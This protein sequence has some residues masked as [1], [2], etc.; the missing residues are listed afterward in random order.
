MIDPRKFLFHS[1]YKID[2][3]LGTYTGSLYNP[4]P[5]ANPFTCNT[6]SVD[7]STNIND[8]TF[9]QGIY[10]INGG[11]TWNDLNCHIPNLSTP[12]VPAFQTQTMYARSLPNILRLYSDNWSYYNGSTTTSSDYTFLYKVIIFAKSNQ[13]LVTPQPIGSKFHFNSAYNYQKIAVDD[14]RTVTIPNTG[15]NT[16]ISVP[17]NLNYI[18]KVRSFMENWIDGMGTLQPGLVDWGWWSSAS[19]ADNWRLDTNNVYYDTIAS[20]FGANQT[21]TFHTRVYFDD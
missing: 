8:T 20:A 3:I 1:G 19:L 2:Q 11:G 13:G 17:H 12:S 4:A 10:S 18:P 21:M 14:V 9:F 15:T 7:I 6:V 16:T 5:A